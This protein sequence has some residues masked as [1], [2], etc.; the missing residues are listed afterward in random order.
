MDNLI[1]VIISAIL[2]LGLA[3][4]AGSALAQTKAPVEIKGKIVCWKDS[5]GKTVG[6]GDSVPP[7]YQTSATKE[8]DKRGVTRK[9]TESAA[10]QAARIKAP[11]PD[12]AK[13]KELQIEEQRKQAD[14]KRQD[15]ALINTF[16]NENEIDRKRDRE[17][18]SLELQLNQ[19]KASFKNASNRQTEINTRSDAIEK[20]KK[21]VPD[22]V[23]A[24]KAQA[25][26]DINRLQQR[27]VAKE[28]EMEELRV[29]YAEYRKRFSELKGTQPPAAPPTPATGSSP[30]K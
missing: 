2:A 24:E 16:A 18:Q 3:V 29:R 26:D 10:D 17:L 27:I 6:C 1:R 8:L 14:Q 20:S 4:S 15:N 30:K 25:T 9:T 22:N 11:D 7:E 5:S 13:Q 28:K 21:A 19:F 23:K 12:L